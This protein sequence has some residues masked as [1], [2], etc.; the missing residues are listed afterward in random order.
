MSLRARDVHV[1]SPCPIDLDAT[2]MRGGGD[3]WH[4]TH[5]SKTVYVLSTMTE[6][7]ARGFLAA[8]AGQDVCVSYAMS[9]EGEIR[10]RPEPVVPV[11][12]LVRP[13]RLAAAAIG[14]S[15]AMAA[16]APHDNPRVETATVVETNGV[17]APVPVIPVA[18]KHAPDDVQ[19]DGGIGRMPPPP[20]PDVVHVAGGISVPKDEPCDPPKLEPTQQP[21]QPTQQPTMVRGGLRPKGG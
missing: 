13:R 10:F 14:L 8:H 3:R 2:G 16:C 21:R 19:V 7:Q 12:S 1:T 6:S 9:K 15:A 4:C 11:A 5:C 17:P 18:Q 20:P